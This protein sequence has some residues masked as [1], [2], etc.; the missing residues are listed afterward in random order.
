MVQRTK[1]TS[2]C[3]LFKGCTM[4]VLNRGKISRS[5]ILILVNVEQHVK[6]SIFQQ[7]CLTPDF[8]P[9]RRPNSDTIQSFAG[10]RATRGFHSRGHVLG[11][12]VFVTITCRHSNSN[13]PCDIPVIKKRLNFIRLA[14]ETTCQLPELYQFKYPLQRKPKQ[15]SPPLHWYNKHCKRSITHT[16]DS[17]SET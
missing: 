4:W 14:P 5:L 13:Q 10:Q 17:L 7:T 2:K 8:V 1:L 16:Q 15:T 6:F 3:L 11:R 12:L 9:T